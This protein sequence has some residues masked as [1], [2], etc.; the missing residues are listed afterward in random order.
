MTPTHPAEDEALK[1]AA[2]LNTTP[3]TET[4]IALMHLLLLIDEWRRTGQLREHRPC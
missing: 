1:V 2:R 4:W 3:Q